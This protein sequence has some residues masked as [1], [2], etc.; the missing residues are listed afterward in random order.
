MSAVHDICHFR[1][2]PKAQPAEDTQTMTH[3]RLT[4]SLAVRV[5]SRSKNNFYDVIKTKNNR[6]SV[7]FKRNG[8]GWFGE[9][10]TKWRTI[11]SDKITMNFKCG[12]LD[13]HRDFSR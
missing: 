12:N 11:E 4:N 6:K 2:V 13:V 1:G 5:I 10:Q 9:K 3:V 7:F 8:Q